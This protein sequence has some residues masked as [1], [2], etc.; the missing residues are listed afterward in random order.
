MTFDEWAHDK[1]KSLTDQREEPCLKAR[2]AKFY[3]ANGGSS[4]LDHGVVALD[5]LF[6][7]VWDMPEMGNVAIKNGRIIKVDVEY[8]KG[9]I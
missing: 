4:E 7:H 6:Y 2:Y 9:R 5:Q 3:R 1:A 8:P